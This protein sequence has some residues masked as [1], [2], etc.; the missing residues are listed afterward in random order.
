MIP[1]QTQLKEEFGF[2]VAK[3]SDAV[4]GEIILKNWNDSHPGNYWAFTVS[5]FLSCEDAYAQLANAGLSKNDVLWIRFGEEEAFDYERLLRFTYHNCFTSESFDLVDKYV[6]GQ[7][8]PVV[9]IEGVPPGADFQ[10]FQPETD[11]AEKQMWTARRELYLC[12]SRATSFLYFVLPPSSLEHIAQEIQTMVGLLSR[13]SNPALLRSASGNWSSAEV[14]SRERWMN[15]PTTQRRRL[16]RR[17]S[18]PVSK[19]SHQ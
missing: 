19:S 17:R 10:S 5:T 15:S 18:L 12:C 14:I 7:E 2:E 9:V 11:S 6:K 8:F 4:G 13:P 3:W 1:T 16:P